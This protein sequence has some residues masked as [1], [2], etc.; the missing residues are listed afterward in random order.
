MICS[1]MHQEIPLAIPLLFSRLS[2]YLKRSQTMFLTKM[3]SNG[4]KTSPIMLLDFVISTIPKIPKHVPEMQFRLLL[5][6]NISK[7]FSHLHY[8]IST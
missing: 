5:E 2:I 7:I 8:N 6:T 4:K 3:F 1:N